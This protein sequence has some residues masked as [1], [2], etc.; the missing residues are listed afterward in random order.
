MVL[1]DYFISPKRRNFVDQKQDEPKKQVKH[2]QAPLPLVEMKIE[3]IPFVLDL[4]TKRLE[5]LILVVLHDKSS[6]EAA[7]LLDKSKGTIKS[8]V[9]RARASIQERILEAKR[10][11]TLPQAKVPE[12]SSQNEPM[13]DMSVTRL[14]EFGINT[15]RRA[16]HT[17][18]MSPELSLRLQALAN[19]S[20]SLR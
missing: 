11:G 8:R 2:R 12:P 17:N 1:V 9:H 14:I 13:A 20:R 5:A 10:L 16:Y 18:V 4:P 6:G 19:S 15:L 7:M 3:H